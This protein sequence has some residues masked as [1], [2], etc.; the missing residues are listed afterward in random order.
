[1]ARVKALMLGVDGLSYKFFMKCGARSLLTLLDTTF[2]GVTENKDIQHPA[3]AWASALTGKPV[4]VS[5]YFPAPPSLPLVEELEASLVNVPITNPTSGKVSIPM[6]S[7]TTLEAE[8]ASVEDVTL[9][10]LEEGPVIVAI[11]ALERLKG[12]DTCAAYQA[13]DRTVRRLV[14]ASD[15]FIVF[16]PYGHPLSG[17][18][19]DPYGVY[20]ASRPRPREHDTVK[21][22]EIGSLF[23]EMVKKD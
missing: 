19:F 5:G 21:V 17:G 12:Y 7:T 22:W 13:I 20:L 3:A 6:D 15:A 10:L 18:G 4:R 1:M 2:R 23:K 11:T 9:Q 16:S 14:N 8:L